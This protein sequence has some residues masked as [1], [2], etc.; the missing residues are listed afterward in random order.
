MKILLTGADG[1]LGRSLLSKLPNGI[2]LISTNKTSLDLC[3]REKCNDFILKIKPEWIINCAAYT[4]VDKAE[5]QKDLAMQINGNIIE[6]FVNSAIQTRTKILHISTDFVFDGN[7]NYPYKPYQLKN[8]LNFYGLTKSKGEDYLIKNFSI[9]SKSIILRTSWL[10]GAIGDNFATKMLKLMQNKKE[11]RVVSDQIGCPTSICSLSD[12]IWLIIQNE[13]KVFDQHIRHIP[14]L[15]FSN[16]GAASWYDVAIKL[17][18]IFLELNLIDHPLDIFPIKTKY[19]PTP[20]LR[21]RYSILDCELTQKTFNYK[22]LH[23]SKAL[24]ENF[25]KT[26]LNK[27]F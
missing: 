11:L 15:H 7:Q 1:Q 25:R 6:T 13:K 21:P 17:R 2:D 12:M 26:H 5:N 10:M 24:E 27:Y 4:N 19:Y 23:W 16:S 3:N 18:D 9:E 14:I 22:Q 20:A 8:P